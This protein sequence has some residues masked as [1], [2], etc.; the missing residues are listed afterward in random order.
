[1]LASLAVKERWEKRTPP[2]ALSLS[3]LCPPGETQPA[4]PAPGAV[5]DQSKLSV[6]VNAAIF[7]H[8]VERILRE[9]KD[10]IGSLEFDK[11]DDLAM[12]FVASASNLRMAVF[13]IELQS[14]F[15]VKGIAGNIVHA[16]AT[17]NAMAAGLIVIE[18]LK[19]PL[20]FSLT[21]AVLAC[22]CLFP[23]MEKEERGGWVG[24]DEGKRE[25]STTTHVDLSSVCLRARMF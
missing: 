12:E 24:G 16:I 20:A 19:V 17:T 14:F 25:D 2:A 18:G 4:I 6:S 15:A 7:V 22:A 11:D 3:S 23:R 1:M 13:G 10:S 8:A 9:R 5:R 21:E